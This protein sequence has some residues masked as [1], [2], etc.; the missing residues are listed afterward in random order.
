MAYTPHV[1]KSKKKFYACC[2]PSVPHVQLVAS[3]VAPHVAANFLE[4]QH[5]HAA[6]AGR[7]LPERSDLKPPPVKESGNGKSISFRGYA[8]M[9][10]GVTQNSLIVIDISCFSLVFIVC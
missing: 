9:L 1:P 7:F 8:L 6:V 3:H 4:P 10:M 2:I 5:D